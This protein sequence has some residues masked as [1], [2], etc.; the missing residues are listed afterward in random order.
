MILSGIEILI[1]SANVSDTSMSSELLNITKANYWF[2]LIIFLWFSVLVFE[3][4]QIQDRYAYFI[5]R[6]S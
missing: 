3:F 6:S 4:Y 5:F 1:S 2:I